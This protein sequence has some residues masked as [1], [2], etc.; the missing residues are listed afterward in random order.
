MSGRLDLLGNASF[1]G[2]M[3]NNYRD[4][5]ARRALDGVAILC[6]STDVYSAISDNGAMIWPMKAG[7]LY[8]G[9]Q[10]VLDDAAR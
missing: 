7:R 1:A 9:G 6:G 3:P 5:A 10:C 8:L 2:R 4:G